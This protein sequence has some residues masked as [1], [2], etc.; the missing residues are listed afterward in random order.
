MASNPVS[1]RVSPVVKFEHKPSVREGLTTGV[2]K[3]SLRQLLA[4]ALVPASVPACVLLL[5]LAVG[6]PLASIFTDADRS[7]FEQ[8]AGGALLITYVKEIFPQQMSMYNEIVESF[9]PTLRHSRRR[10]HLQWVG[11][12]LLLLGAIVLSVLIDCAG[13]GFPGMHLAAPPDSATANA[14]TGFTA[15][16]TLP[17]FVGFMV[18]GVVLAYD[19]TPV[20]F[21]SKLLKRL[22]LS[23]VLALDNFLDGF[24]AH[25]LPI[26]VTTTSVHVACLHVVCLH[27]PACMCRGQRG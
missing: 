13:Q 8:I 7:M 19:D 27:V 17:Y 14:T 23:G 24:G 20:A 10:K 18:D 11:L 1:G 25:P 12:T 9:G 2:Q 6:G 5:A 26:R 16:D 4:I 3:L 21:G 15:G 22:I